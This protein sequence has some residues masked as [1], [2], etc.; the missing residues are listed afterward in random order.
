MVWE[1][2]LE[3]M[4]KYG[5]LNWI[6]KETSIY[7]RFQGGV[8]GL[9]WRNVGYHLKENKFVIFLC[10]V[11]KCL[12]I[13]FILIKFDYQSKIREVGFWITN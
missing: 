11:K 7:R 10:F 13:I 1:A 9:L 8:I 6:C 3:R 5:S 12:Q 2:F 4:G